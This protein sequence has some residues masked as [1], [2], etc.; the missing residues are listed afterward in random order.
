MSQQDPFLLDLFK[1]EVK[2]H[3]DALDSGLLEWEKN[4]ADLD[5][6]APLMRA[7]H[8]LKGAARIIGLTK[9]SEVA[10]ELEDC[11]VAAQKG[12]LKVVP[13]HF[14]VF[15]KTIDTLRSPANLAHEELLI[16]PGSHQEEVD[17]VR[18]QL[19]L[20][21]TGNPLPP[22]IESPTQKTLPEQTQPSFH[23]LPQDLTNIKIVE[24]N[25]IKN[26]MLDLCNKE[27]L[28]HANNIKYY[29]EKS[30][31]QLDRPVD[32]KFLLSAATGIKSSCNLA[33]RKNAESIGKDLEKLFT[34]ALSNNTELSPD[35][36]KSAIL[37]T[38]KLLEIIENKTP[39]P[40]PSEP[41]NITPPTPQPHLEPQISPT[42]TPPPQ[43]TLTSP[44]ASPVQEPNPHTETKQK[45]LIKKI[46]EDLTV[47]I[48]GKNL[49]R[50]MSLA[51][52]S[53]VETRRL[54]PL[55]EKILQSKRLFENQIKLLKSLTHIS[56]PKTLHNNIKKLE[57]SLV[58][59]TTLFYQNI[60]S[61][62][63][64]YEEFSKKNNL[65]STKLYNE[66]LASRMRPFK[67]CI[68][69]FP[70]LVRDLAKTLNKKIDLEIIGE[71]TPVDRDILEKLEAPLNHIIRNSCDHGIESPDQRIANKKNDTG[72]IKLEARHS[73]GML[74][75]TITDDGYGIDLERV[76]TKI[77]EKKL[78]P[79][80]IIKGFTTEELMEFL[81]LP[82]FS[83]AKQVTEISGRGVGLDAVKS[84]VQ[85]VSG[86]VRV[87]S[88]LGKG[89]TFFLHLPITRSVIRV[90]T[91]LIGGEIYAFP[92]SKVKEALKVYKDDIEVL[93]GRTYFHHENQNIAMVC[94]HQALGFHDLQLGISGQTSVLI[95]GSKDNIYS[96]KVDKILGETE[97]VIRPL[98][99][100]LGKVPCIAGA[101]ITN[102]GQPIL[103]VDVD[104]VLKSVEK[105]LQGG[106]LQDSAHSTFAVKG[107]PR[108]L[109]VDDS[110]TVRQTQKQLLTSAGYRVETADD[111][112][113][114]WNTIRSKHFDLVISD[115]DM[116]R[117]NGFELLTLIKQ[118]IKLKSIPVIIVSYKE[119]NDDKERAIAL[120]AD[121]YLSKSN[122]RDESFIQ[123][124]SDLIAKKAR[125]Q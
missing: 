84:L 55:K 105:L 30:L 39:T 56:N 65:L 57:E 72:K 122:F 95:L 91:V 125:H 6:I 101:S 117:K 71:N 88:E 78:A 82:G 25:T 75:L 59:T 115:I 43:L 51:A 69:G 35:E 3:T 63:N 64:I 21:L 110:L 26:M 86:S 67:E 92:L 1:Q 54:N 62:L 112:M 20:V 73:S 14:D 81:F 31:Q 77:R 76:K 113:D 42:S 121:I 85:E 17:L 114:G 41:K 11:L 108:I 5:L 48:S 34:D 8:S 99:D 13:D 44:S 94:A 107:I 23:P 40:S 4:I 87:S 12:S 68:K 96:L 58:N 18:K 50:L 52:E 116:P 15:L 2:N 37:Q 36:K 109:I 74:L 32:Y 120:G 7:A 83:T 102:D 66:V 80:D 93:A 103:I 28:S 49:N 16:W 111:G 24:D 79:E 97:L 29:L 47:R 9:Y 123:T 27:V 90:I 118:D 38:Q 53:L 98:A 45:T 19:K 100:Q 10:H 70:R 119:R 46:D 104:D 60:Q 106:S 124:I 22:K 33:K 89:T 61:Q